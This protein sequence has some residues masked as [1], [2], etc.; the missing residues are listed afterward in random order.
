M[1]R[2]D[3]IEFDTDPLVD[4]DTKW[5]V[6]QLR[7]AWADADRLAVDLYAAEHLLSGG[8]DSDRPYYQD[9]IAAHRDAVKAREQ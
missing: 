3:D 7:A 8:P 9:A 5:L 6:D 2:L 1:S 4:S